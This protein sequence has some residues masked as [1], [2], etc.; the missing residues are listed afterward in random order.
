L[1]NRVVE[2]YSDVPPEV[3]TRVAGRSAPPLA[4]SHRSR[5]PNAPVNTR[6]RTEP[7]A[8]RDR[9]V[10]TG[11]VAA[12]RRDNG[13]SAAYVQRERADRVA[14]WSAVPQKCPKQQMLAG[15]AALTEVAGPP[16]LSCGPQGPCVS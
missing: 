10:P 3:E 12:G 14:A 8:K 13:S 11:P 5:C 4:Q 1:S 6:P 2:V 7:S 9:P 15:D 16:E